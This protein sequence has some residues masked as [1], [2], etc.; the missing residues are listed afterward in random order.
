MRV[1]LY[2]YCSVC[3]YVDFCVLDASV[4]YPAR[5]RS[6]RGCR[7][8]VCMKYALHMSL[9]QLLLSV[10]VRRIYDAALQRLH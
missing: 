1:D 7:L 9:L 5:L 8:Y 2:I 6:T 4:I 3:R 10:T